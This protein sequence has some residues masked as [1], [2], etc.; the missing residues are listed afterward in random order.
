MARPPAAALTP[1]LLPAALSMRPT[2]SGGQAKA[3]GCFGTH[4]AMWKTSLPS[5][6]SRRVADFGQPPPALSTQWVGETTGL[7]ATHPLQ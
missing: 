1:I 4:I 5:A 2:C 6:Q 7:P 3:A